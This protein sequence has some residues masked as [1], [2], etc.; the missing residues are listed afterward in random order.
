LV[1]E[2]SGEMTLSQE[3]I[4]VGVDGSTAAVDALK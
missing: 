1:N 2:R 4:V 3:R